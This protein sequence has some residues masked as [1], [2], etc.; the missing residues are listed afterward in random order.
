MRRWN[1]GRWCQWMQIALYAMLLCAVMFLTYSGSR[2][3]QNVSASKEQNEAMRGTLAYLQSQISANAGINLQIEDTENGSLLRMPLEES[4]YDL[5]IY[6]ADGALREE[7]TAS[8]KTAD[9][10]KAQVIAQGKEFTAQWVNRRLLQLELD[11]RSTL[12]SFQT[13][14]V[15]P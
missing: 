15:Q 3:Y 8:G 7:V 5:L 12:V 14:E 4:D 9:P 10:E 6:C 11:G 13:G 1:A 2:L